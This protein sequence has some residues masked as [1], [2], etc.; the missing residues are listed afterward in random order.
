MRGEGVDAA[1]M[2]VVLVPT[3][4]TYRRLMGRTAGSCEADFDARNITCHLIRMHALRFSALLLFFALFGL[5]TIAA[6]DMAFPGRQ[7]EEAT[8]ASQGVAP[9]KLTSAVQFLERHA[10]S[11]GVKE[12]VIVR[13]GRLIWK[14]T[15]IDMA[16]TGGETG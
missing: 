16:S 6:P 8:P 13:H 1:R 7:W 14:G 4:N 10:G 5:S 9:D 3:L 2:G 12:V 15:D 11:D